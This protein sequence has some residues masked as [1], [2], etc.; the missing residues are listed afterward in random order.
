MRARMALAKRQAEAEEKRKEKAKKRRMFAQRVRGPLPCKQNSLLVQNSLYG[1]DAIEGLTVWGKWDSELYVKH[2]EEIEGE[3]GWSHFRKSG[4]SE[5]RLVR[6]DNNF[7]AFVGVV[8]MSAYMDK[9]DINASAVG[10]RSPFEKPLIGFKHY[11]ETG[12]D[13]GLD[14]AITHVVP[15]YLL[16][17]F[18]HRKY[19]S[20][21]S[22][23]KQEMAPPRPGKFDDEG[24]RKLH[25]EIEDEGLEPFEHFKANRRSEI[26][27]RGRAGK[28]DRRWY[29]RKY[30]KKFR[31]FFR[32]GYRKGLHI[33]V[34]GHALTPLQHFCTMGFKDGRKLRMQTGVGVFDG[35]VDLEAFLELHP[36]A[37]E[38]GMEPL[39]YYMEEGKAAGDK[40]PLTKIDMRRAGA[41]CIGG[42]SAAADM[43]EEGSEGDDDDSDEDDVDSGG[44]DDGDDD[45]DDDDDDDGDDE[46]DD[47]D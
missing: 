26:C 33:K 16:G 46:D 39:E 19:I 14:I 1:S 47:D 45:S 43:E 40:L 38:S 3:H 29:E 36:A 44:D 34:K 11:V 15:I 42:D 8:D 35:T 32:A 7:G 25:P 5:G 22:N 20:V 4:F 37:G 31:H 21:N 41:T 30:Q 17:D 2:N 6:I 28:V 24:Y 12:C 9:H 18:N 13:E 23:A 10:K 27:V